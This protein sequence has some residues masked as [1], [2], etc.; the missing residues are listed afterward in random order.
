MGS[1]GRECKFLPPFYMPLRAPSNSQKTPKTFSCCLS[2]IQDHILFPLPHV[3]PAFPKIHLCQEEDRHGLHFWQ[4]GEQ[5]AQ[6]TLQI[7]SNPH[8]TKECLGKGRG[9]HK[10]NSMLSSRFKILSGSV[11]VH[12]KGKKQYIL[13]SMHTII[14]SLM[15]LSAI[16]T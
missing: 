14:Q 13:I 10:G 2:L 7:C 9:Q 15:N 1:F 6:T 3:L 4:Q 12:F 11:F 16:A 5:A 8:S